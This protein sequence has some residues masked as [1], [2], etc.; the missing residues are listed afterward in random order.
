MVGGRRHGRW[1]LSRRCQRERVRRSLHHEGGIHIG[2]TLSGTPAL[3]VTCWLGP[4]PGTLGP[5]GDQ[6]EGIGGASSSASGVR[7]TPTMGLGNPTPLAGTLG[8]AGSMR[9]AGVGSQESDLP[10]QAPLRRAYPDFDDPEQAKG[11]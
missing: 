7:S 1:L 6:E 5:R 11:I 9:N 4:T 8:P 10:G 3:R 2:P